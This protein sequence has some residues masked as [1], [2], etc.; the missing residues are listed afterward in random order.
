MITLKHSS[1]RHVFLEILNKINFIF[2][3]QH[4]GCN[5]LY[6]KHKIIKPNFHSLQSILSFQYEINYFMKFSWI[7][8]IKYEGETTR[9]DTGTGEISNSLLTIE[10]Q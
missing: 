9:G 2:H 7:F 6:G 3:V 8:T 1:Q 5:F 10:G 4:A